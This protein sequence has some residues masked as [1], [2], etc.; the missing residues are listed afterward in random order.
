MMQSARGARLHR[1]AIGEIV[2]LADFLT[3]QNRLDRDD[4]IDDRIARFV[5]HAHPTAP[6]RGENLVLSNIGGSLERGHGRPKL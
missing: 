1:Q 2:I 4:A 6:E 3:D 5:D